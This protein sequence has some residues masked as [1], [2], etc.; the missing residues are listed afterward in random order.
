M[1][2]RMMVS[3]IA[4][5]GLLAVVA[6]GQPPDKRFAPS[7]EGGA[8]KANPADAVVAGALANDP[9]VQ[10][11]R[12][13]VLLAEAELAKAKQGV[14]LKV[15]SLQATIQ[16]HKSALAAA[17]ERLGWSARMVEKG[18]VPQRQM[19]D[20]RAKVES[21]KAALQRAETELKLLT[22]SGKEM[23][24]EGA[25][26][27]TDV[28][29]QHGLL[30]LS[31]KA[32]LDPPP[33]GGDYSKAA[34]ALAALYAG[35]VKS[36]VGAIPDRIRA[37]LDKQVRIGPKGE[38]VTFEQALELFKKEAGLDVA[39]RYGGRAGVLAAIKSEGEELPIGAWF[40]LYQDQ[41]NNGTILY[42]RD[43]GLLCTTK[44]TAPSDAPTLTEFWKQKPPEKRS[45]F[46]G[47]DS[48]DPSAML[49]YLKSKRT[50][51]STKYGPNHPDMI[52]VTRQIEQLEKELKDRGE[53]QKK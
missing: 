6:L 29:V 34:M 41:D 14:V 33:E 36:P 37:A 19:L 43:Y 8:K 1:S 3:A 23:G 35:G 10:V 32:L 46:L 24:M 31:R 50:E 53:Q 11:A 26:G 15:M 45:E 39:V 40:Q 20:E 7:Q 44:D 12:A 30:W 17:E 52:A 16:E 47:P 25:P 4:V 27:P 9:D 13:K 21:A 22:G 18:Q 5:A 2:R 51:M 28:A 49:S 42:V 38:T 48:K